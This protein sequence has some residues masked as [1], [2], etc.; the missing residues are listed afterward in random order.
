MFKLIK[1]ILVLSTLFFVIFLQWSCSRD[2]NVGTNN[3]ENLQTDGNGNSPVCTVRMEI[4]Q[5]VTGNPNSCSTLLLDV[6]H[7]L[8]SW[9]G[10]GTTT[11]LTPFTTFDACGSGNCGPCTT[12]TSTW[13]VRFSISWVNS[14]SYNWQGT[15]NYGPYS[16]IMG[17]VPGSGSNEHWVGNIGFSPSTEYNWRLG[18]LLLADD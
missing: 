11:S 13:D 9:T 8:Q 15:F 6:S 18:I 14:L 5:N 3:T 1:S 2:T 7:S 17:T 16:Y 12:G 10:W 4:Y